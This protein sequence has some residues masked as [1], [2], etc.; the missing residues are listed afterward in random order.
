MSRNA[1]TAEAD[2]P[3]PDGAVSGPDAEL[4][5]LFDVPRIAIAVD[6]ADPNVIKVAFSGGVELDRDNAAQ[7]QFYNRL[8]AGQEAELV[9][10]VHVAG[11]G[12]RHR[13]DSEGFVDAVVQTKSLIV[14]DVHFD[15]ANGDA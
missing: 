10:T 13:R 14:S 11:A 15:L 8:R 7:V 12:N 2:A 9:V 1:A 4:G 5:K 6:D 3:I